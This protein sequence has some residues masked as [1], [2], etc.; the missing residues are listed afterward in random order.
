MKVLTLK[1]SLT[2]L[3]RSDQGLVARGAFALNVGNQVRASKRWLAFHN[4]WV[5]A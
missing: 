1:E 4:G 3:V 5:Q 2:D